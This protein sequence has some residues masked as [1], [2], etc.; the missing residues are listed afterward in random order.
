MMDMSP[1]RAWPEKPHFSMG[2]TVATSGVVAEVSMN[3]ICEALARHERA[4]WGIMPPEDKKLNDEAV[5]GG[6][7]LVSRWNAQG[8]EFYVITEADRSTTTVLLPEEY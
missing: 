8:T 5:E 7:R 6:G 4:D 2:R 1:G 3:A